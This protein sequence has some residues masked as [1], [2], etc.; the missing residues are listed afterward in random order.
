MK[1]GK[2]S[3]NRSN[4][5]GEGTPAGDGVTPTLV[6][7]AHLRELASE[8]DVSSYDAPIGVARDGVPI[9][10]ATAPSVAGLEVD[11]C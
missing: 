10:T 5:I 6:E 9:F 1:S 3:A 11:S 2:G 4:P 8:R 7:A